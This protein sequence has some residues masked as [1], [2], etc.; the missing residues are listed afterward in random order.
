M[1]PII[2]TQPLSQVSQATNNVTVTCIVIANPR[3]LIQWIFNGSVLRNISDTDGTKYLITNE[4]E[5]NCT[6][7]DPPNQCETSS[8]LEIFNV[9][10]ADSGEYICDASNAAGASVESAEL[11]IIGNTKFHMLNIAYVLLHI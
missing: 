11:T 4:T 6:I 2:T 10:P 8:T 9:Q 7:T 5:G 3:A 1:K